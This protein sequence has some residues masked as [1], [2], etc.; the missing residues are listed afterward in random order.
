MRTCPTVFSF[1]GRMKKR[2]VFSVILGAIVLHVSLVIFYS[3]NVPFWD[4]YDAILN[5]LNEFK[6]NSDDRLGLLLSQHNEHRIVLDRLLTLGDYY[7]FG[8]INIRHLIYVGNS[9]IILLLIIA[10][11]ISIPI[12]QNWQEPWK[13][14]ALL[15]IP[16]LLL[17]LQSWENFL[18]GMA[19]I[20]NLGVLFFSF[21]TFYLL[22]YK[23]LNRGRLGLAILCSAIATF[24]SGNG[25]L[26]LF[27]SLFIMV[28]TKEKKKYILLWIFSTGLLVF[29]YLNNY[30]SPPGHPSLLN[31]LVNQKIEVVLYFLTLM[32]SG[33]GVGY[34]VIFSSII[35]IGF[36]LAFSWLIKKNIHVS[37]PLLLSILLFLLLTICLISV[38]RAGFTAIQALDMRYRIY[39]LLL[40][41]FTFL[42][43]I[44]VLKE[45]YYRGQMIL[46]LVFITMTC[47]NYFD[48]LIKYPR[49]MS[50]AKNQRLHGLATQLEGNKY[51]YLTYPTDSNARV[52]VADIIAKSNELGTYTRKLSYVDI[53]SSRVDFDFEVTNNIDYGF[54]LENRD[55]YLFVDNGW[56]Y[57]EGMDAEETDRF[58]VLKSD[59]IDLVY[60][61]YWHIRPDVTA[62]KKVGNLDRSGLTCIIMKNQ[63]PEGRYKV[64]VLIRKERRFWQSDYQ[65]FEFTDMNVVKDKSGV[66]VGTGM[67][68][69]DPLMGQTNHYVDELRITN[70]SISIKG[71][72]IIHGI[73]SK[74]IETSIT[75]V[76]DSGER[77]E[78]VPNVELRPD[79]ASA[80]HGDYAS[81]GFNISFS[82]KEFKN[83]AYKIIITL[84]HQGE[85]RIIELDDKLIVQK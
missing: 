55:D 76:S 36:L 50:D 14:A 8:E 62:A 61:T 41:A 64:G 23:S 45:P 38:S 21:L 30:Y 35:G 4:D 60:D 59:S 29:A 78:M 56:A 71:W 26:S 74:E 25:F 81:A 44:S 66:H 84:T 22:F 12:L 80:L 32:S 34:N 42:A 5:F 6:V 77:I 3:T 70:D 68:D 47:W 57:I 83:S 39:S 46:I 58:V 48:S 15:P 31:A 19:S 18:W 54:G 7:L 10:F 17:N 24:T 51:Y 75:F 16:F 82:K 43:I 65:A 1:F 11:R 37:N 53:A 28:I 72:A 52:W 20:Q 27:I 40:S 69:E 13:W 67:L 63:I 49:H 9:F 2:F 79:V 85:N 33:W 73:S